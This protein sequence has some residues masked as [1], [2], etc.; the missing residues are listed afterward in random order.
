MSK[1]RNNRNTKNFKKK[2]NKRTQSK[3]QITLKTSQDEFP[4][5]SQ[6]IYNIHNNDKILSDDIVN[7]KEVLSYKTLPKSVVGQI[8]NHIKKYPLRK[9]KCH[10]NSSLLTLNIEGVKTCRGWYSDSIFR[11]LEFGKENGDFKIVGSTNSIIER[12]KIENFK[13]N[14]WVKLPCQSWFNED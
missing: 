9:S 13:G 5:L 1:N 8:D 4:R 12:I 3:Q 11:W 10:V 2:L 7:I 14:P 6:R